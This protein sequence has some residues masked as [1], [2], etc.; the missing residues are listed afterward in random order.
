MRTI[1]SYL[2]ELRVEIGRLDKVDLKFLDNRMLYQL[3]N[4]QRN[5]FLK[6][7]YNKGRSV[8]DNTKQI[9]NGIEL[10]VVS[11]STFFPVKADTRI[12][13]SKQ[14]IPLPIELTHSLMITNIRNSSMISIPYNYVHRD[15]FIYA[16]NGKFN[17]KD[18]YVTLYD[19]HLY[20][21]L[22][23]DNPKIA[24]LTHISIEEVAENPVEV[25]MMGNTGTRMDYD[26]FDEVYPIGEAMWTYIKG[27]IL[28]VDSLSMTNIKSAGTT[29]NSD[30]Q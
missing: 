16:G 29:A 21:K 26:P 20:I 28:Q 9:I 24:M 17:T 13:K 4:N 18:I 19:K 11:T 2:D 7:E 5:I 14:L 8:E 25:Y 30:L 15:R 12:L 3:I 23:K 27:Y 6:N 10:E 1:S 22:R